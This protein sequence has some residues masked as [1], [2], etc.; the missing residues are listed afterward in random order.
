M[1]LLTR[2][3]DVTSGHVLIDNIDTRAVTVNSLRNRISVVPQDT[4]LFDETIEYNIQYGN[5]TATKEDIERVIDKCNLRPTID[6]MPMG[7]QTQVCYRM[8]TCISTLYY[9]CIW[10]IVCLY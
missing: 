5:A 6:K 1:R 9:S 3:F 10:H 8:P 7:L 4:S 2:M